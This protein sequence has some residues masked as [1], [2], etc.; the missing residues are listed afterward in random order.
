MAMCLSVSA[1]TVYTLDECLSKAERY[2]RSLQNALIDIDMAN[3][4]KKE[5]FTNYFPKISASVLAFRTFDEM[6][7]GDG[8]IPPEIA[9]LGQMFVPLA[10]QPFSFQELNRGYSAN[11]TA[12]QPLFT[13]GR[14][15][16]GNKLASLQKDVMT[17]QRS[18]KRKEVLQK[19]TDNYWKIATVKYNLQTI[20]AADRQLEAARKMVE[21]YV[22]AGLTTRNDLLK[23]QLRQQELASARLKLNNA[24]HV[25]RLLLAQMIGEA[26]Q[27]IDIDVSSF[28]AEDPESKF[29]PSASA[30]FCREELHLAE[31]GVEAQKLQ[32]RMERGKYLPS[33]AV[34][35]MGMQ[36]GVGGFSDNVKKYIDTDV[37]NGLVFGTVS[38]PISDWW[39]GS[40]A[41][42]RQKMKMQQARNDLLEARE[43]LQIDIEA[44]WSNLTE[45]YKQVEIAKQS[46][47]QAAENLRMVTDQY[48]AGTISLT[49]FLD[50]ETLNRQAR[51]SMSEAL[52]NY[53]TQ[54]SDY[55]FKTR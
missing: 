10:G 1:Q 31:L 54:L 6:I 20:D 44:S 9:A 43:K 45:A 29:V 47:E 26:G 7:K 3:E 22:N 28:E 30:V 2:N 14:I 52:A 50:A 18:L 32:V 15:V 5:A 8:I 38:I 19:V 51:S 11:I 37:T 55:M 23:V 25:L 48:Q 42:R 39:G 12:V 35:V 46:V 36:S 4:Q 17:L 49:D 40:H 16:N 13:G 21:D 53:Q 24:E 34:G 41:L 33:V 27:D